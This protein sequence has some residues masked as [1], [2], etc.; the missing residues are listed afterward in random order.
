MKILIDF[1]YY[2]SDGEFWEYQTQVIDEN[3]N[4]IRINDSMVEHMLN[5]GCSYKE[6]MK[7][8]NFDIIITSDKIYKSH[9]QIL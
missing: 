4:Q 3:F 5:M 7:E 8:L 2:N 1:S 9:K 6:I